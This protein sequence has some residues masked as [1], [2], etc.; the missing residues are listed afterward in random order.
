MLVKQHGHNQSF[1]LSMCSCKAA[2]HHFCEFL[3][4]RE[5]LADVY[6]CLGSGQTSS[7]KINKYNFRGKLL[8]TVTWSNLLLNFC[9]FVRKWFYT[10]L[11]EICYTVSH[12]KVVFKNS[13]KSFML[14]LQQKSDLIICFITY[15]A[16]TLLYSYFDSCCHRT[17][18]WLK[19]NR[20]VTSLHFTELLQLLWDETQ[21]LPEGC[22]SKQNNMC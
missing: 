9:C 19:N 22:K 10:S 15:I 16:D 12:V 11:L 20:A 18:I 4:G 7:R 21:N 5:A 8:D 1:F 13:F 2:Y 3:G 6:S 14:S 17:L